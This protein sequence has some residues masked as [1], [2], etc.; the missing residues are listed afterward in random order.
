MYYTPGRQV[1][2][3]HGI[4][5][6]IEVVLTEEEQRRLWEADMNGGDRP[7]PAD[8]RQLLKAVEVLQ[9]YD[10]YTASRDAKFRKLREP[11]AE[12]P[13]TSDAENGGN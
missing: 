5:P 11:V 8:D 9:T 3:E 4:R 13:A 2:H 7:E 10:A 6:D 12:A 1:I